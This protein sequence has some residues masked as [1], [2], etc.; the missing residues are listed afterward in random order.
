MFKHFRPWHQIAGFGI[1]AMLACNSSQAE[2]G[3]LDR[4]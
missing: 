2:S 1:V 3:I 4:N